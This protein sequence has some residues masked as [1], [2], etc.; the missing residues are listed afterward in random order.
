M[1]LLPEV[2][3][4]RVVGRA[5]LSAM[6]VELDVAPIGRIVR[7]NGGRFRFRVDKVPTLQMAELF[8][9]RR[10][11]ILGRVVVPDEM[12]QNQFHGIAIYVP[13]VSVLAEH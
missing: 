1:P 13:R 10:G 11:V 9:F 4:Q 7:V 5:S 2:L 3:R 6:Q 12:I 8:G